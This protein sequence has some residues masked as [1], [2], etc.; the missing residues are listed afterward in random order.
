MKKIEAVSIWYNGEDVD[1]TL[2]QVVASN[3]NLGSSASLN[4][5]LYSAAPL[6]ENS[7]NLSLR[8]GA[9]DISGEDYTNWGADDD[10]IWEYVA[11][12]LNLIII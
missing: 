8:S 3:V 6:D 9:L 10:Y 1:A 2:L 11:S 7:A 4:Y 5:I 12:K